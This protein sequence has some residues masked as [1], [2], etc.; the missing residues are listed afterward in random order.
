MSQEFIITEWEQGTLDNDGNAESSSTR[1]R[2]PAYIAVNSRSEFTTTFIATASDT[3]G[4]PLKINI[5]MYDSNYNV[6]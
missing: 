1:V 5:M 3:N 4:T 6:V 2:M